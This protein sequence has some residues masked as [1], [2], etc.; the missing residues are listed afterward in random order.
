MFFILTA[1]ITGLV[2][3]L[4]AL[5]YALLLINKGTLRKTKNGLLPTAYSGGGL[6]HFSGVKRHKLW[7]KSRGYE[8]ELVRSYDLY[9]LYL[10]L[11]Q[12]YKGLR[13]DAAAVFSFLLLAVSIFVLL[14]AVLYEFGAQEYKRVY[15][16]FIAVAAGLAGFF[17]YRFSEAVRKGAAKSL[18][19]NEGFRIYEKGGVCFES[20]QAM[21][22]FRVING[23]MEY[24]RV[25]AVS[26][27][28]AFDELYRRDNC[29][30]RSFSDGNPSL[31]LSG[32]SEAEFCFEADEG[33]L[34]VFAEEGMKEGLAAYFKSLLE[35][36]NRGYSLHEGS[37]RL[38]SVK[39]RQGKST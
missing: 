12:N 35:Q 24:L 2:F 15:P 19:L 30:A 20:K 21:L 31:D 36:G 23:K 13:L 6:G 34:P 8:L 3:I 39:P 9:E 22:H 37:W 1:V 27:K 32:S 14:S 17:I 38:V 18:Q 28:G 10:G 4:F 25:C 26:E 7:A 11:L 33:L 16:V 5:S 29:F